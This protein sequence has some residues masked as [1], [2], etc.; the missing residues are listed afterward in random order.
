MAPN[1]ASPTGAASSEATALEVA[2]HV[3]WDH[4]FQAE[5]TTVEAATLIATPRAYG[6]RFTPTLPSLAGGR[7][8]WVDVSRSGTVAFMFDFAGDV[9]FPSDARVQVE[10]SVSSMGEAEFL[11]I[12]WA[13]TY[14][15]TRVGPTTI[16]LQWYQGIGVAR[17]VR[18]GLLYEV[19]GPALGPSDALDL[20]TQLAKQLG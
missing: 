18:G 3:D 19:V 5:G 4:P 17:F 12:K 9:R 7:I 11:S 10:E 13:G 2:P 15:L 16:L 8:R 6:L 1:D 14:S 20:A